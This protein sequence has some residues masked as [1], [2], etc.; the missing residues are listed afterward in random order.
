MYSLSRVFIVICFMLNLA[1]FPPAYGQS[2]EVLEQKLASITDPAEQLEFLLS[3]QEDSEGFDRQQQ[4]K[5]WFLLGN[6]QERNEQLDRAVAS[7]TQAITLEQ[8]RHQGPSVLQVESLLERSYARYLQTYDTR[9]Y[10]PDRKQALEMARQLNQSKLLVKVLVRYAFCFK[11]FNADLSRGLALLDE[12]I[13]IATNN[14]LSPREHAMIY[15]ASGLLYQN[16]NVYEKSYDFLNKA[17]QQ[18]ASVND[19]QD[20]FNMQ[21]TL[22]NTAINMKRFDLAGKHVDTLF[23]LAKSQKQFKD[24]IFFSHFC[25]GTLALAQGKFKES[26]AQLLLALEQRDKTGEVYFVRLTYEYLVI[27]YFRLGKFIEA[28]QQLM[29]Y[30]SAFPEYQTE[31]LEILAIKEFLAGNYSAAMEQF[32]LRLDQEVEQRRDFVLRSTSTTA[33]LFNVNITEL[34]NK[35]LQQDLQI[36]A[37]Q[38]DKEQEQ[39]RNAYLF[40]LLVS[41]LAFAL[42]LLSWHLLRTR[43]IFRHRAQTDHLTR[44][45][46]RRHSFET[47]QHMLNQAVSLNH[48]MSLIVFDIDHFKQVNDSLGHETGDQA[49][50]QVVEKSKECLRKQ[51]HLGRI[52]GEEFLLLLPGTRQ[53]K[54]VEIAERIRA[55]VATARV[56]VEP[57]IIDLTVS[58]GVVC[59]REEKNLQDL[60]NRGDKALYQAKAGGRNQVVSA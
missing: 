43:K 12:A 6:H 22:V 18:W 20:M 29:D 54:A 2:L 35:I 23:Y 58:L 1:F 25:A 14:Q 5:Y 52:G 24:F 30:Q 48:P 10:C 37:L 42:V 46:N 59:A 19:Y 21:F 44:I 55:K 13:A 39:K 56:G 26:V 32:Y 11:D 51:D 36:N 34:D 16:Y 38:F 9:L 40:L 49:I 53:G 17:Y 3:Y 7:Y 57:D 47:G 27:S 41:F 15:N 50:V 45:A 28:E 4:A 33:S 31:S 60:I 8:A